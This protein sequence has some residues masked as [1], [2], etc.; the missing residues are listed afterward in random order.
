VTPENIQNPPHSAQDTAS[1][2][3]HTAGLVAGAAGFHGTGMFAHSL[4]MLAAHKGIVPP[5]P[6]M[7]GGDPFANVPLENGYTTG[8]G[9]GGNEALNTAEADARSAV[10]AANGGTPAEQEALDKQMKAFQAEQAKETEQKMQQLAQAQAKE[11]QEFAK[12]NPNANEQQRQEFAKEQAR[13]HQ[14]QMAQ[15][16]QEQHQAFREQFAKEAATEAQQKAMES[17]LA[18]A[19][20]ARGE[21]IMGATGHMLAKEAA[22]AGGADSFAKE[23]LHAN[24]QFN[25]HG[26][27][28]HGDEHSHQWVSTL[29][30][31]TDPNAVGGQ[32]TNLSGQTL[33]GVPVT[34]NYK[35]GNID[36]TQVTG[37]PPRM[38]QD[39]VQDQVVQTGVTGNVVPGTA[40]GTGDPVIARDTNPGTGPNADVT[41]IAGDIAN[42][43]TGIAANGQWLDPNQ[44]AIADGTNRTIDPVTGQVFASASYTGDPGQISPIPSGNVVPGNT[45]DGGIRQVDGG[46][47]TQGTGLTADPTGGTANL[48]AQN[49]LGRQVG[50]MAADRF[51]ANQERFLESADQIGRNAVGDPVTNPYERLTGTPIG[52]GGAAA[53][54]TQ[55]VQNNP[56]PGF[57]QGPDTTQYAQGTGAQSTPIFGGQDAQQIAKASP[58]SNPEMANYVNDMA[59]KLTGIDEQGRM[60]GGF[61][62]DASVN[63]S[64]DMTGQTSYAR[65]AGG[66]PVPGASDGSLA[67]GTFTDSSTT[68]GGSTTLGGSTALG[69][70]A[71]GGSNIV[72]GGQG[73]QP[74]QPGMPATPNDPS[75]SRQIGDAAYERFKTNEERFLQ[76]GEQIG[77]N[78]VGD[79]VTNPYERM[80]GT[81]ISGGG[82]S[83]STPIAGAGAAGALPGGG[84]VGGAGGFM[85]ADP[86]AYPQGPGYA[87][88]NYT[89]QVSGGAPQPGGGSEGM[90]R[91]ASAPNEYVE[92]WASDVTG[93]DQQGRMQGGFDAD[94]SVNRHV[95]SAGL[96]YNRESSSDAP[97]VTYNRESA[98]GRTHSRESGSP[99]DPQLMP[100]ELPR[101]SVADGATLAGGAAAANAQHLL[102][103]S[104]HH[105]GQ[106]QGLDPA[107]FQLNKTHGPQ[108]ASQPPLL[109]P[110]TEVRA[111]LIDKL[112]KSARPGA[113]GGPGAKRNPA[114]GRAGKQVTTGKPTTGK[115]STTTGAGTTGAPPAKGAGTQGGTPSKTD[116]PI[117]DWT[118]HLAAETLKRRARTMAKRSAADDAAEF[119]ALQKTQQPKKPDEG[120]NWTV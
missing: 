9:L 56:Q 118:N 5:P 105:P 77:R 48:Q 115:P 88:T 114:D 39:T 36:L 51:K 49:D 69:G 93:I 53:D 100:A 6:T 18:K 99:P 113:V 74:G 103:Q 21:E 112:N 25:Y 42:N 96:T 98:D 61:N 84:M 94:A 35:D 62:A 63:R 45:I 68:F 119:E 72:D 12:N 22:P 26:D 28:R 106:Q 32:M 83:D 41:R 110:T 107:A 66:A 111:Y 90:Q 33:N 70:T 54:G 89:Q 65:E 37:L 27:T 2:A 4:A 75:L 38:L 64:A 7:G 80:T 24:N 17:A 52:S 59:T 67:G 10:L 82:S 8:T 60:P 79:P 31:P 44:R 23:S 14:E 1:R 109:V 86:N 95:D 87:Q 19:E 78:S 120:G 71:V 16:V 29:G 40:T 97:G 117:S 3:L 108:P 85:P 76:T 58:P 34:G 92:Q 20:Q 101:M 11:Q 50:D 55:F 91:Q 102:N 46:L 15:H 30:G 104:G 116:A 73:G 13:Q 81:P 47:L 57:A 43:A